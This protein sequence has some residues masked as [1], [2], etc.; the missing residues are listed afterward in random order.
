M[1]ERLG[2]CYGDL[3]PEIRFFASDAFGTF[4]GVNV[5]GE[6]SIFWS[7]TGE[8]EDLG[9]D[10]NEFFMLIRNDPN[11]TIN[12]SLYMKAVETYGVPLLNE[13]FA[14]KVET[15]L[16]GR[17]CID[18]LMKCDRIQYM[19]LLGELALKI[20]DMPIGTKIDSVK[21]AVK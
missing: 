2:E 19:R 12:Y 18:N 6:V 14:F 5:T 3:M 9:V 10:Q 16:G 1:E 7:E 20:G 17:M 8:L 15:S 4:Y 21:L 13:V 11:G